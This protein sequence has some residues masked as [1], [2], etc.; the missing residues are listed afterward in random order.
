MHQRRNGAQNEHAQAAPAAVTALE[1]EAVLQGMLQETQARLAD[2]QSKKIQ[3]ARI[4]E[5]ERQTESVA[6]QITIQEAQINDFETKIIPAA[7]KELDDA[8]LERFTTAPGRYSQQGVSNKVNIVT[9]KLVGLKD[10]R[11]QRIEA[12]KK[13]KDRL[14]DMKRVAEAEMAHS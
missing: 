9:A 10:N 13:L 3:A 8:I 6:E 2:L 12:V 1:D 7:M 14:A 4:A 11:L 5:R